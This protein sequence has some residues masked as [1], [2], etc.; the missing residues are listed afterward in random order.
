VVA[1]ALPYASLLNEETR[2]LKLAP[3]GTVGVG[4]TTVGADGAERDKLHSQ[5]AEPAVT[6]MRTTTTASVF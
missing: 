4:L 5:N 2:K 3:V 1:T 6:R